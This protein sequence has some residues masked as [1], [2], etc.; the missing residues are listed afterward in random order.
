MSKYL[1]YGEG[2]GKPIR[3]MKHEH[4][5]MLFVSDFKNLQQYGCMSIVSEDEEGHRQQWDAD[6]K[7][8][9]T[10]EETNG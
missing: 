10:M 6:S 1:I 8:W 5:A 4:D 9:I 7:A 2:L 3:K